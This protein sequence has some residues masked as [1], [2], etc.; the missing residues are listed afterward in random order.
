MWLLT[1]L[2]SSIGK[3]WIMAGTGLCLILFLC[4]HAAGNAT[5]FYSTTLFQSYADQLHSHPLI[6]SVFSKGLFAV[7][8]IHIVTGVLLFLQNRKAR[9]QNY[10]VHRRAYKNSTASSTMIYT[11]LF[12]LLF[13]IIHTA[14]VSFGD[15]GV[16]ARTISTMFSS[17]F[18]SMFYIAAFIV[19]AFHMSHGLWSMLQTFGINHPRYTRFIQKLTYAVPLFFLLLFGTIP[20][21]FLFGTGN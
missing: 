1:F 4:S 9:P 15:H 5:L 20:L 18:L 13:A 3:K 7:F 11:G 10:K 16:I 6:V 19:L 8:A 21:L 14:A 2:R 17:F 12:I